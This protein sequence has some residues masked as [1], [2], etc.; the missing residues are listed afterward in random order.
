V[1]LVEYKARDARVDRH[2]SPSRALRKLA[3]LAGLP[4]F[5]VLCDRERPLFGV[6]ALN[7]RGREVVPATTVMAERQ[8]AAF[9]RRL[10]AR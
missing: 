8:F 9:Q 3:D 1:D 2:S 10:R 7:D 4:A 5:V 6:A